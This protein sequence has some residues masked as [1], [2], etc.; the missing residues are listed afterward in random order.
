[1]DRVQAD[2]TGEPQLPAEL[3]ERARRYVRRHGGSGVDELLDV[4]GLAP[5]LAAQPVEEPVRRAGRGRR[6]VPEQWR[7]AT[8]DAARWRERA[9]CRDEEPELFFP[10]GN[11]GPALLQ[12]AEAKSVCRTCPVLRECA[13]WALRHGQLVGVWGGMSE[14]ERQV[15]KRRATRARA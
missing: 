3:V 8:E 4:L 5:E 11:T 12:I 1:M 14:D 7:P 6:V 9:S 13:E 15:L 2:A 10:V